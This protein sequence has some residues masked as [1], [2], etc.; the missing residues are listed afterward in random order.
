MSTETTELWEE[1]PGKQLGQES[2]CSISS[3][4]GVQSSEAT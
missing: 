2:T 1:T 4:T 3:K